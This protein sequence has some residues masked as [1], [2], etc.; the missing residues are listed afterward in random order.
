MGFP[1]GSTV[2]VSVAAQ[3]DFQVSTANGAYTWDMFIPLTAKSGPLNIHAA[4]T[5]GSAAAD[6]VL[7]VRGFAD[8]RI[9]IAKTQGDNQTGL[10]GAL[11]PQ[12]LRVALLDAAGNPVT[13][14]QVVF[15]ASGGQLSA[16]SAVTDANGRAE[17]FLRL[18]DSEGVKAVTADA[19][20]IAQAPVTFFV[21]AAAGALANF[22][23]L[24]QAGDTA[25][26]NGSATIAQKGAL[27]T[28]VAAILRYRQN[29]GELSA[30]NGPADP[31]A[32][33]Q[34]LKSY[35]SV[36]LKGNPICDGF[37][38]SSAAAEQIVNL[39]RAADFTG[40]VD[41][42]VENPTL[43]AAAD[44]VAA[45]SPA[46][47][48]LS[49]TRNGTPA[50]G[51]FVVATGVAA[52]GSIAIHDPN[53]F[54]ARASL[55]EYLAG[56]SAGGGTWKATLR[57][58]AQFALRSP[59]AS[60]FL[61]GAVSQSAGLTE[62]LTIAIQSA[63]GAC[64][65]PFELLDSVDAAGN[66]ATG[67]LVSRF[68]V[69]DGLQ[70]SYQVSVGAAQPFRAF[71]QD[72]A[73]AGALVDVSGSAPATYQASRP[74]LNLVLTA[75]EVSFT[76]D[77]IVNGATFTSGIAPGGIMTIF[78]A[79]LWGAGTATKV[80]VDGVA[81][82]VLAAS[83]F[84]I[85]A[86]VPPGIPAGIHTLRIRS[87]YGTA[88]QQIDVAEVAPAIFLIGSPT[89]G[90]VVNQDLKLNDPSNPLPRGQFLTIYGTGFGA[91]VPQ[92]ALW[93]TAAPVTALVNGQELPVDFA[94][95]TPG[96]VGLYQVNLAIPSSMPPGL[97]IS[98]SL[99]QAGV[100]SNTIQIAL[101]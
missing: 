13:G 87:A 90:A 41:V 85:N 10:P 42:A 44:L 9:Q 72:L 98:L 50:G 29:R 16:N 46:L 31:A 40:G 56:F 49:L 51:H 7:T 63:A 54:F 65:Q 70:Q 20:S 34:Y 69:C 76:A 33:N 86:Q 2:R 14:A 74:Q 77:G 39:W 45:G 71:V 79:G 95:L 94:G 28:S 59:S 57:G 64:G 97:G 18:P 67:A 91:V 1:N 61:V 6:G 47:L 82:I 80:D 81:A 23:K 43:A 62:N 25:L 48:S 30:P 15:Q 21:R 22:P 83:P 52:D 92:G 36:D 68:D 60:R 24:M 27:L 84:Q 58:V 89:V 100:L 37:L 17:V 101:H 11:L 4:D 32:L 55:K 12:A 19:P 88:Q 66:P 35:C 3:P 93:V 5:R 75:Q 53:P 8:N 96:F 78:G 38:A 73:S 26:G 99:R